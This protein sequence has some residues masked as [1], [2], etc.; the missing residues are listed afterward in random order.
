VFVV[1]FADTGLYDELVTRS[2]EPYRACVCDPEI[3]TKMRPRPDLVRY[4]S[5]KYIS[6]STET[7]VRY[8]V[9]K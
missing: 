8:I 3:S 9:M 2:E 1:W 4:V 6:L 7:Y 5:D